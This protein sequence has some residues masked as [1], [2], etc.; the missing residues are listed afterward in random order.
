MENV[1]LCWYSLVVL[2]F[3]LFSIAMKNLQE[4]IVTLKEQLAEQAEDDELSTGSNAPPQRKQ[5]SNYPQV[6][7]LGIY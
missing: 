6:L 4:E 5:S 2:H 3:F 7:L 1:V